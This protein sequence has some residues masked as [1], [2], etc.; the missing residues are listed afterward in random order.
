[1]RKSFKPG[2]VSEGPIAPKK[3]LS[4]YVW[5]LAIAA[6]GLIALLVMIHV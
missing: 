4:R 2:S 5:L 3:L 6:A 1:M